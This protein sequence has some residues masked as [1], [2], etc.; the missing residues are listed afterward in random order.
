MKL[1]HVKRFL[2]FLLVAFLVQ[3]IHSCTESAVEDEI[4]RL[5]EE[6]Q[7]E[8]GGNMTAEVNGVS[9][10]AFVMGN[11]E[12]VGAS[13]KELPNG[14]YLG[15]ISGYDFHTG[16]TRPKVIIFCII[17]MDYDTLKNGEVY[18]TISSDL[19]STGAY[20]WYTQNNGAA[21]NEGFGD[22]KELEEIYV[23]ITSIDK[24]KKLISGEFNYKGSSTTTGKTY[25][26]TKGKFSDVPFELE[27]E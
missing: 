15:A 11:N 17:G 2:T 10:D 8:K 19:I 16:L 24:D 6:E 13:I 27:R 22:N 4:E 18:D 1:I 26:I 21:G 20:A 3:T 9:F 12:A 25:R 23:K 14:Q 7:E 5:G